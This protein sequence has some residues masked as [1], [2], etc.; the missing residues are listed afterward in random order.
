ML[1]TIELV[2]AASAHSRSITVE[3]FRPG[4]PGPSAAAMRSSDSAMRSNVV[5][6]L[7]ASYGVSATFIKEAHRIWF[8]RDRLIG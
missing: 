1:S 8:E 4:S 3:L 6:I 5:I 2:S 7:S